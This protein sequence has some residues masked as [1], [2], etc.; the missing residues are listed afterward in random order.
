MWF[1][2][3]LLLDAAVLKLYWWHIEEV[4]HALIPARIRIC[5]GAYPALFIWYQVLI[6]WG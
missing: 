4:N 2:I 3:C 1:C 6:W 5:C